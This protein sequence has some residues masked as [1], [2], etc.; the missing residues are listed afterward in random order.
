MN[1]ILLYPIGNTE[2]IRYAVH[3]LHQKGTALIDHPAPEVTHLLLDVPS[4]RSDGNLHSGEDIR[5]HLERLP[6]GITVIG[7]NLNHP[8]L[9]GYRKLD[10]VKDE[11]YLARNAAIT[12]DC[13]LKVAA[14]LLITTF[15]DTPTLVN[16]W[17]RIGKCLARMLK[18][19]G[20]NVS[21]AARKESD[22]AM[23]LALGYRA[24]DFDGTLENF[25]LIFNTVPAPI[26]SR[27]INDS[28]NCVKIDLA[29]VDGLSGD[30]VIHARGLPG[31]LAPQSSGR[32]IAEAFLKCRR[33]EGI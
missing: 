14:P 17:G 32:L 24:V 33:E 18:G 12:A 9:S 29:S 26:F 11:T 1:D 23:L 20:C 21:V 31:A 10:L 5:F 28:R 8:E 15:A 22:R 7:G 16:G 19:L 13:A 30:D 25:A 3:F 2:A 6:P 27:E 4:F